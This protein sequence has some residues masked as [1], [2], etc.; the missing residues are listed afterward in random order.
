MTLLFVDWEPPPVTSGQVICEIDRRGDDW[1]PGARLYYY[2]VTAS[3]VLTALQLCLESLK[4]WRLGRSIR[5]L[6]TLRCG[7]KSLMIRPG[8]AT[9][10]RS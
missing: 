4:S 1:A 9:S 3:D 5:T 7:N 2:S 6:L 10:R 8:W